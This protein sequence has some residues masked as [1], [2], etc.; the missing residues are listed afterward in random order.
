[1]MLKNGSLI[2]SNQN[3]YAMDVENS[4]EINIELT[5]QGFQRC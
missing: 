4:L 5:V 3:Q 1:M 2:K